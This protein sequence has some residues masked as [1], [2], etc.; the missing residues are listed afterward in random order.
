MTG[1]TAPALPAVSNLDDPTLASIA[2]G[3]DATTA[4]IVIAW[5]VAHGFVVITKPVHQER[6]AANAAGRQH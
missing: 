1:W 5:H 6:I 2:S 3:H 4:Q